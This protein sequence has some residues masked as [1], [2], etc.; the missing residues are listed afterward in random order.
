L[1]FKDGFLYE[2]TGQKGASSIRKVELETGKVLQSI[3]LENKYFGEGITI[4]HNRIYQLTWKS[5]IGFVYDK[6]SF[7]QIGTFNYTSEGWGICNDGENLIMSDGTEFLYIYN[8][9]SFSLIKKIAVYD[10]KSAVTK[11]NELEYVDGYVYA[12]VYQTDFIVKIELQTGK[13][14]EW[15]NLKNILE[16]K[17]YHED[18][19]VLNGIAWNK[20]SK[21]FFITGKKWPKMFEVTFNTNQPL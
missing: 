5:N 15:I 4:L 10:D 9:E 11:L 21:T 8:P 19:D 13:V 12:N 7:R 2:A 1:F 18:I 6:A 17:Y 20:K 3:N 14:I 16:Q